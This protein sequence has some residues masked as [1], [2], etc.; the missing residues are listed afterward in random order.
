MGSPPRYQLFRWQEE[1]AIS[2]H[3][4]MHRGKTLIQRLLT[5]SRLDVTYVTLTPRGWAEY[6]VHRDKIK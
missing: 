2:I 1:K 3:R 4:G 5:V 6:R